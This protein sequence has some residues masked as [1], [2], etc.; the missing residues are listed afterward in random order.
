MA[1]FAN[2][3]Q[4]KIM[5]ADSNGKLAPLS[6]NQNQLSTAPVQTIPN[7]NMVPLSSQP[8]P[9]QQQP[10][11]PQNQFQQQ[12]IQQPLGQP[13]MNAPL[14]GQPT[15]NSNNMDPRMMGYGS[16]SPMGQ[17]AQQPLGRN[18]QE[19]LTLPNGQ[20]VP[21]GRDLNGNP[22]PLNQP[23]QPLQNFNYAGR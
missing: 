7:A 5:G 16:L 4:P 9:N 17:G 14:G 20:V 8:I 11:L 12:P 13:M 2:L 3:L 10:F 1:S 6:L 15:M 23:M 19:Q 21:V 22:Y 18:M